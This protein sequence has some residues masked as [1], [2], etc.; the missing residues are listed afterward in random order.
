MNFALGETH[1][2]SFAPTAHPVPIVFV[3]DDDQSI[4]ESLEPL[5]LSLG[6]DVAT[7]G[8]A[9][10]FLLCPIPTG[11]SCLLLDMRLPDLSGFEVQGRF[12]AMRKRMPVVFITGFGDVPMTVRA[13]KAGA[14]EVLTKP[15]REDLLV[16]AIREALARSHRALVQENEVQALRQRFGLLSPREREVMKLVVEGLLNKQVGGRLGISEITVKAHRGRVMR[17]MKARTFAELIVMSRTLI[18]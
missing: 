13:M 4:R 14:L 15:L 10:E 8:T 12:A 5:I 9:A 7:F 11:P 17:K 2:S 1:N 3:V 6:L 16:G 18:Y